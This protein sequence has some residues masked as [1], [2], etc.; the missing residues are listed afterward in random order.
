MIAVSVAAVSA[1]IVR[2]T[3]FGVTDVAP[4]VAIDRADDARL[5]EFAAVGDRADRR[6][7]L[8]RRDADLI[9][10]RHRRQRAVGP[11]L[12]LPDDAGAL[13][14]KIGRDAD[15]R[16]RSAATKRLSR[17]VPTLKPILI[18]PTLLDLTIT[19]LNDSTP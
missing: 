9:A 14:G 15:G 10:H 5:D 19:S 17:S 6:S 16:S 1:L 13:A 8:Q 2:R 3:T 11:L 4:A 7:H 18:A 12:G